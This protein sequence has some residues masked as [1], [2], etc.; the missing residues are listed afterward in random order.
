MWE[1]VTT[2][3]RIEFKDEQCG[4]EVGSGPDPVSVEVPIYSNGLRVMEAA[5][6]TGPEFMFTAI[7]L[8]PYGYLITTISGVFANVTSQCFWFYYI[9]YPN[10]PPTELLSAVLLSNFY[11]PGPGYSIIWRYSKDLTGKE[12]FTV[13]EVSLTKVYFKFLLL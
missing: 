2:H 12:N 9:V 8:S 4:I 7:Y 6:D 3:Y 11:I 10:E 5:A 13:P 1:P